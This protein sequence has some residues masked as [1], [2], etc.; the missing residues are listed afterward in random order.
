MKVFFLKNKQHTSEYFDTK[1]VKK[2]L[3]PFPSQVAIMKIV[4]VLN[5][6]KRTLYRILYIKGMINKIIYTNVKLKIIKTLHQLMK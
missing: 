5:I 4:L 3:H 1:K 6:S 2:F